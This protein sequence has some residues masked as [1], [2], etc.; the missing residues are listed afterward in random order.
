M[1]KIFNKYYD[2]LWFSFAL[3][4]AIALLIIGVFNCAYAG[5][6]DSVFIRLLNGSYG[7]NEYHLIFVNCTLGKILSIIYNIFPN[8]PWYPILLLVSCCVSQATILYSVESRFKKNKLIFILSL[9]IIVIFSYKFYT[10][11]QFTTISGLCSCSSVLAFITYMNNKEK[12]LKSLSLILFFLSVSLRISEAALCGVLFLVLSIDDIVNILRNKEYRKIKIVAKELIPFIFI[13][14]IMISYDKWCYTN[15]GFQNYLNYNKYRVRIFDYIIPKYDKYH[16]LFDNLDINKNAYDLY[17]SWNFYDTNKFGLETVKRLSDNIGRQKITIEFFVNFIKDGVYFCRYYLSWEILV[18]FFV[19]IAFVFSRPKN[20][21]YISVLLAIMYVIFSNLFLY[22]LRGNVFAERVMLSLIYSLIFVVVISFGDRTIQSSYS[23]VI[24]FVACSFI[25]NKIDYSIKNKKYEQI[26][27]E[28]RSKIRE[29]INADNEHLY[30][31]KIENRLFIN[32]PIFYNEVNNNIISLGGW[33]TEM[34]IIKEKLL[35][36]GIVN[37][38]K[39]MID[40]EH[41]YL[42]DN[43]IEVTLKYLR[44]YYN[45]NVVASYIKN[46]GNINV[47]KITTK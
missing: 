2:K 12:K 13:A 11:M 27:I 42:L 5:N 33:E 31:T 34:P 37:P 15:N 7:Y 39:D 22:Y 40:N 4:L 46:I 45:E 10:N 1:K 25:Y 16:T 19:L 3:N 21:Y 17:F 44:D 47:Y 41:V 14:T 23:L 35:S 43:N 28:K 32:L 38:Y 24:I 20:K 29:E 8:V 9:L 6:D 36:Y 26:E 18:F 30:L